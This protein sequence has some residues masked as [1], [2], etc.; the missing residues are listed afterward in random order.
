M[1]TLIA[2]PWVGEFGWE[3]AAWQGYIRAL[4]KNFDHL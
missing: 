2:G 1:K 3:L 4:S